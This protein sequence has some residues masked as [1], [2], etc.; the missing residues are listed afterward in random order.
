MDVDAPIAA[1]EVA[2][3]G[4]PKAGTPKA[5]AGT[6]L[7]S[8]ELRDRGL[9]A[10]YRE[11]STESTARRLVG[12][13][14][15]GAITYLP[16]IIAGAMKLEAR[17]V[18]YVV[19]GVQLS[20]AASFLLLVAAVRR[21][22]SLVHATPLLVG[23]QAVALAAILVIAYLLPADADTHVITF[24]STVLA[25]FVFVPQRVVPI[26]WV[27]MAATGG[28][29]WVAFTAFDQPVSRS[30]SMLITCVTMTMI[31]GAVAGQLARSRREQYLALRQ[32]RVTNERLTAEIARREAVEGELTHLAN[33]D[34]LTDLLNRR[35]FFEEAEAEMARAR[36]RRHPVA[37]MMID[38]DHF[39]SV[40]DH[41]GHHTGD[42]VLKQI[43]RACR[44]ELRTDDV[45]GR[46]GGEEF[47]ALL[48]GSDLAMAHRI[49][50]RVRA[51]VA[52]IVVEHPEGDVTCTLSVGV[53]ECHPW[54][55]TV[56]DGMQRADA[57]M[58]VAKT[59]GRNR[60]VP[61]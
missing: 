27:A 50:E 56:A 41:F 10:A 44:E 3:A 46:T 30:T 59:Q 9:E 39:K 43:A 6:R 25:I 61:A 60:V 32:E 31:S 28:F 1:G 52:S 33:H 55:E 26:F 29:G 20:L 7:F 47:A 54:G 48:P 57:A 19:L 16:V 45:L 15:V 42:E 5:R 49:A 12:V 35:A 51:H 37:L 4:T 17:P 11:E 36:R 38:A 24:M 18:T 8:G 23:L 14:I 34:A 13:S 58:Y 40:N 21:R 53:V 2:K 22:P